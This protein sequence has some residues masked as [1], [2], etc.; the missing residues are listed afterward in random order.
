MSHL[1]IHLVIC[2]F[3]SFFGKGGMGQK[4][5]EIYKNII[6]AL[7]NISIPLLTISESLIESNEKEM[8]KVKDENTKLENIR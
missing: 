5:P 3:P 2:Q 4:M 1:Y 8:Q 6:G 7:Q